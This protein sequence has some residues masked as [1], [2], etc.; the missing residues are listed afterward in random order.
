MSWISII[1]TPDKRGTQWNATLLRRVFGLVFS[2]CAC[3]KKRL[4]HLRSGSCGSPRTDDQWKEMNVWIRFILYVGEG[5]LFG[6]WDHSLP[7]W[8]IDLAVFVE[9]FMLMLPLVLGHADK[10]TLGRPF[11]CQVRQTELRVYPGYP[12]SEDSPK[13]KAVGAV[14]SEFPKHLMDFKER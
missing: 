7:F 14:H 11:S 10:T 1:T 9:I 3:I 12:Y 6:R 8:P 13:G 5:L 4:N 2:C